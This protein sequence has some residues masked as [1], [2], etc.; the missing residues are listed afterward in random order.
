[1]VW[2]SLMN[3]S[4]GNTS[5]RL[6]RG[7]PRRDSLA[8]E[9]VPGDPGAVAEAVPAGGQPAPKSRRADERYDQIQRLR[10]KV[11]EITMNNELLLSKRCHGLEA[12]PLPAAQAGE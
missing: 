12:K 11:G 4:K 8:R 9:C 2:P 7:E 5:L 6:P 3:S 1:M 10:A